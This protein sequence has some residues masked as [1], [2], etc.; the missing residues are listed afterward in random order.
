MKEKGSGGAEPPP[1][2]PDPPVSP[3]RRNPTAGS[4]A[5]CPMPVYTGGMR[6]GSKLTLAVGAVL[7]SVGTGYGLLHLAGHHQYL[8]TTAIAL[9][10]L[11][12][13]GIVYWLARVNVAIPLGRLTASVE[14]FGQGDLSHRHHTGEP[15]EVALLAHR[16]NQM[17]DTIERQTDELIRER[18]Y[19]R[20]ILQTITTG[21]IGLDRRGNITTWNQAVADLSGVAAERAVGTP[22]TAIR[23]PLFDTPTL[24]E[25][26]ALLSGEQDSFDREDRHNGTGERVL[27]IRGRALERH[28]HLDGAVLAINDRTEQVH[29]TEQLRHAEKLATVGQLAA[30]LAHEIGT[31]LNVISGRAEMVLKKLPEGDGLKDHLTRIVGQID[32]ISGIVSQMLV[33]ARKQAPHKE[34]FDLPQLIDR[35]IGLLSHQLE[36]AHIAVEWKNPGPLN[37]HADPDQVQQV[38]MN[39]LINARQAMVGGG[40]IQVRCEPANPSAGGRYLCVTVSDNGPGMAD[41]VARRIFDPFFTTKAP[42]QGTG[43]GLTVAHGIVSAHGGWIDVTTQPGRGSRFAVFLPLAE[44]P[45]TP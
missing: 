31:P 20:K 44:T 1:L 6:V 33:F 27:D 37:L 36:Q 11:A 2:P 12:L 7:V 8:D 28:G 23:P 15:G 42:G 30:G 35:L 10:T 32:R 14:R 45:Q 24:N 26:Q 34:T 4:V 39:L 40:T 43:M 5:F 18:E 17:A 41:D 3:N 38:I 13:L 22:L 25:I 21:I 9:V 19:E 16:F 29:L